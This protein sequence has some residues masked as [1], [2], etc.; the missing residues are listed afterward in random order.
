MSPFAG[1]RFAIVG[2]GRAGLPAARRLRDWGAELLLWDDGETSRDAAAA[3][4]FALGRPSESGRRF[5]ALLLSPGIPHILPKPHQEAAWARAQGIAILTDAEML[6]QA[7]RA[8]GSRAR[9]AG[10]TGTNGKSTTT[11]LLAHILTLA[12]IPNAA[13]ANLGPAAL[14]LPVLPDNG[15][16]V[17]E[18]S[19]YM[20]ER[21]VSLRFDAAVMLNLSSDHLDR[22]GDMDGYGAAKREIFARQDESCTAV[23]GMDDEPSRQMA[24]WL[25]TRPAKLVEIS[26]VG[27][28]TG[29]RALRGTHNAQNALAAAAMAR[30]LGVDEATIAAG[31]KSFPGLAHRAQEVAAREGVRFVN[32]SK[33]TNADAASRAMGVYG[34]FVWIAGGVAKAGGI[35]ELAPYFPRIEKAFLIGQDGAAFARRLHEAGVANEY[36]GTLEQAVPAAFMAAKAGGG[37]VLFSPAAASFDQFPN[38]EVRGERFVALAKGGQ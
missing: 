20:L 31:I 14:S 25:R 37:V 10:I 28:E 13:G 19:S 17:L 24:A 30:A 21:L 15:V 22:H 11:A 3:E 4:G 38:F 34:R 6:Y 2:L 8:L 16:Y 23:I 32:D 27:H 5:D 18:M 36:V 35:E 33:A 26:G 29:A 9:F 12:R 1:K 7:V